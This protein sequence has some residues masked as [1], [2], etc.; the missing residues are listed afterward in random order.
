MPLQLHFVLG[1]RPD[2]TS[3][4]S[5]SQFSEA[6]MYPSHAVSYFANQDSKSRPSFSTRTPLNTRT[7]ATMF[8]EIKF[9]FF[10]SFNLRNGDTS[11]RHQSMTGQAQDHLSQPI[12]SQHTVEPKA[13]LKEPVMASGPI[14]P[15]LSRSTRHFQ[16]ESAMRNE[17]RS[18]TENTHMTDTRLAKAKDRESLEVLLRSTSPAPSID[19]ADEASDSSL[20]PHG[21]VTS[22]AT[23]PEGPF[24]IRQSP[25]L[26]DDSGS[27]LVSSLQ[28][29]RLGGLASYFEEVERRAFTRTLAS[30]AAHVNADQSELEADQYPQAFDVAGEEWSEM[31]V[32][33]ASDGE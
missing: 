20:D 24:V 32:Q 33:E 15:M 30:T 8:F 16:N 4:C 19:T 7:P 12:V 13:M 29:I 31:T 23:L 1:K 27:D 11:A 9:S 3:E 5:S 17:H 21:P 18:E 22:A 26:E 6:A 2:H 25:V 14:R 28:R 10:L